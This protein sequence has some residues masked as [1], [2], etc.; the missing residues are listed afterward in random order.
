MTDGY[1]PTPSIEIDQD[2]FDL[3]CELTEEQADAAVAREDKKF[4]DMLDRM[5]PLEQYRY[6]RRFILISIIANRRRLR[7]PSLARIEFIDQLWRDSIK[8]S[9]H[10]LLKHRHHLRT[11][12]W[13]GA[14]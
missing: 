12:V 4:N 10:N 2:E 11:G 1:L 8:K 14:A 13:P 5:T 9:Q 6:W 3:F 7:D